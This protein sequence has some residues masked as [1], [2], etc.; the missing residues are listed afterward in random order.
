[1]GRPAADEYGSFFSGYVSLVTEDDVLPVLEHQPDELRALGRRIPPD[2]EEFAYGDGKWTIRQVLGHLSDTER[3][4]GY[5]AFCIS[6]GETRPLPG[7]AEDDYVA[8]ADSQ[9]RGAADLID[10][11]IAVREANLRVL[12][13]IHGAQWDKR[14][15][16]NNTVLSLRA[17]AY[18]MAGHVRH[19]V[20]LLI[21]RYGSAEA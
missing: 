13:R 6:R 17:A 21:D 9:H 14:G 5:R 18:I 2:R 4:F 1:M 11:F 12:R 19:H 3:V 8:A 10:E 7:F 16:A 15:V 20:R